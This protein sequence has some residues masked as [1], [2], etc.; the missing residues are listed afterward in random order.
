MAYAPK[1]L[2]DRLYKR[3]VIGMECWGWNGRVGNHGYPVLTVAGKKVLGHR[4]SWQVHYGGGRK[5]RQMAG[6]LRQTR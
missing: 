6:R 5:E 4:L 2:F 1:P 3:A